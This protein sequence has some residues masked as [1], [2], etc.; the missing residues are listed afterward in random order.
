[1]AAVNEDEPSLRRKPGYTAGADRRSG[2]HG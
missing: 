2:D 1:V